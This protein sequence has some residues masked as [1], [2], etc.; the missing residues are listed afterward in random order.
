ME[1]NPDISRLVTQTPRIEKVIK[2]KQFIYTFDLWIRKGDYSEQCIEVKPGSKLIPDKTGIPRPENWDLIRELSSELDLDIAYITDQF[3]ESNKQY[4]DN[5]IQIYP[6]VKE[7]F[8]DGNES[9]RNRIIHYA[10]QYD[11]ISLVKLKS[12]FPEIPEQQVYQSAFHAIYL[13]EVSADLDSIPVDTNL[14]IEAA[15]ANA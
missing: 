1:C 12:Y 3:V 11:G 10:G 6:F 7:S 5:L 13:G 14:V 4:L 2:G 8:K 15:D 9:L